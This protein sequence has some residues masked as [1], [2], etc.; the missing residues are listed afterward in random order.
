VLIVERCT[1]DVLCHA[2]A[3]ELMLYNDV[4]GTLVALQ[5]QALAR[6]FFETGGTTS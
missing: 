6:P 1:K 2:L 3:Q 5:L 4:L